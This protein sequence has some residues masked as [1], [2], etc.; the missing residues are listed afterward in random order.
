MCW[1]RLRPSASASRPS[2]ISAPD[3]KAHGQ[4]HSVPP[5]QLSR[6][7]W[8]WDHVVGDGMDSASRR[9]GR[10]SSIFVERERGSERAIFIEGAPPAAAVY[11]DVDW[12]G[13]A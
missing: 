13:H 6:I 2:S 4:S 7:C 8:A 11:H 9:F 3:R 5:E 12:A 10:K 1:M